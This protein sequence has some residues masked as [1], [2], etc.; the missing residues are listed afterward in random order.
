MSLL[1]VTMTFRD[2]D[3]VEA[4]AEGGSA[5]TAIRHSISTST[6]KQSKS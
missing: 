2:L 1:P 6:V 4:L 3:R 5:S